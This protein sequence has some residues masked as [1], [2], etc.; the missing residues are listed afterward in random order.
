VTNTDVP[1]EEA[2]ALDQA[3]DAETAA[4][5]SALK[6]EAARAVDGLLSGT[7]KSPHRGASVVFIE[8]REYRP[9]DDPR[10]LDWRA[11]ARSDRHTIKRFEQESQLGAMLVLD[12]SGSM[13]FQ[14]SKGTSKLGHAATLL[15]AIAAILRA[16][17][18]AVGVLRFDHQVGT[19]VR[20]KSGPTQ[21][22]RVMR[23]LAA[24]ARTVPEDGRA[25]AKSALADALGRL[26]ETATR[27]G[28]IVIASDLLVLPDEGEPDPL[29]ALDRLRARGH[30]VWVLQVMTPEELELPE[31]EAARFLGC[32]G[33]A[34]VEVDPVALRAAY[35]QEVGRFIEDRTQR[36]IGAGA[37]YLLARTDTP[38]HEL[39]AALVSQ[40]ARGS[41]AGGSRWA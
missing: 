19:E 28:L 29:V 3:L 34:S 40:R 2:V 5:V 12:A 9:G 14:D 41:R 38:A 24:P 37:R 32:E 25:G 18:D 33:E 7:H 1:D 21:H 4:R 17:G 23:E 35:L 11:Y 26:S 20:P 30:E 16:Q 10:L 13:D 22:E 39:L 15:A 36:V 8:H 6:I 27:R 31:P